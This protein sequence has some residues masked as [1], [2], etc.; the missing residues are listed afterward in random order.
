ME[1]ESKTIFETSKGS[2]YKVAHNGQSSRLKAGNEKPEPDCEAIFYTDE[3][4]FQRITDLIT[5]PLNLFINLDA[6]VD[7]KIK[8][9]PLSIGVRPIEINPSD[10][11][12][13]IVYEMTDGHLILLGTK[14]GNAYKKG[15]IFGSLHFGHPV[16][17]I[18]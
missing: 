3:D 15:M 12:E 7:K 4:E 5:D 9:A 16:T 17:K 1:K 2:I 10:Q 18:Y 14:V 6:L 11:V 8:L 13:K